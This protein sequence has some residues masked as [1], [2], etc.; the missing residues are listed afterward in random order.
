MLTIRLQRLGKKKQPTYRL[1][2]SEK[3]RDTQ[4]HALEILGHYN[5]VN[6]EKKLEI[7]ED[8]IK[9]WLSKGAQTSETV[10]NLLVKA[11][12]ITEG[13]KKSVAIS[14]K[15]KAKINEKAE[16]G[17]ADEEEKKAAAKA[18]VEEEK[19]ATEAAKATESAKAEEAP[20]EEKAEEV[21]EE[22][23]A[24]EKPVEEKTEKAPVEEPKEE[25][26]EEVPTEESK[27]EAEEKKEEE[28]KE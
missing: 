19:A 23:P 20:V 12:V 27:V 8:R 4:G 9:Y 16:A 28:T 24:E 17:K 22:V 21:K 11:G 5:P 25:K 10:H 2:I 3:A 15:R 14:N 1:V 7:K 13:K 6:S 26:V 18:K